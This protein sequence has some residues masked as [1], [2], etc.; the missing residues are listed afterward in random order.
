MVLKWIIFCFDFIGNSW[1]RRWFVVVRREA[2]VNR[3]TILW[4]K[5]KHSPYLIHDENRRLWRRL[6]RL[7]RSSEIEECLWRPKAWFWSCQVCR[8]VRWVDFLKKGKRIPQRFDQ[9][10]KILED[11][12]KEWCFDGGKLYCFTWKDGRKGNCG[13]RVDAVGYMFCWTEFGDE[14]SL[15]VCMV[16]WWWQQRCGFV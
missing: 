1:R 5:V 9:C 15:T 7:N 14:I 3:R 8:W 2:L 4:G 10:M 13:G 12:W 16:E 11:C 6:L